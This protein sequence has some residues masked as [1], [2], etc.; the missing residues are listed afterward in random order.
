MV[1]LQ[2]LQVEGG[3]EKPP[4]PQPAADALIGQGENSG[5]V[6]FIKVLSAV[7]ERRQ[8]EVY[9]RISQFGVGMRGEGSGGY[10]G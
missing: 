8:L 4:G 10:S 2:L 7:V 5:L 6:V 3:V 1:C 9:Q